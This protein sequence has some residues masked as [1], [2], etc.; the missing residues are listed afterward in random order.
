MVFMSVM[1]FNVLK[2]FNLPLILFLSAA[3]FSF[4]ASLHLFEAELIDNYINSHGRIPGEK[5]LLKLDT[6]P[7]NSTSRK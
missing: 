3:L 7:V 1:S 5:K 6:K 2:I 4:P